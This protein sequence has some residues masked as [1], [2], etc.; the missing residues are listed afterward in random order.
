MKKRIPIL[1]FLILLLICCSSFTTDKLRQGVQEMIFN[2]QSDTN[3]VKFT[4]M[5]LTDA[6]KSQARENIG[7]AALTD[8]SSPYNF[9]GTVAAVSNLP[10]TNNVVNDTYYVTDAKCK[11]TWNGS[12]WYQSSLNEGDYESELAD[13]KSDL[14]EISDVSE[15]IF[16]F[17]NTDTRT[18]GG[19]T[20]EFLDKSTIK[21]NGT[22]TANIFLGINGGLDKEVGYVAPTS[23]TYSGTYS[24]KFFVSG[25]GGLV[26][27]RHNTLNTAQGE[28]IV[29]SGNVRENTVSLDNEYLYFRIHSGNTFT[30]YI[31]NVM[32]VEGS[33]V[34][35][36]RA[37][38]TQY[39]NDKY[40]REQ[41]KNLKDAENIVKLANTPPKKILTW[42]DDDTANI[43]AINSVKE[44]C[45][46]LG[47]RCTLATIT[48]NWTDE[49]LAEL[50]DAQAN[51]YHITT[52]GDSSHTVWRTETKDV[53]DGDLAT[54]ISK[55]QLNG[56]V[57]SNMFVYPGA[58]VDR[59][60]VNVEAIVKKWCECAVKDYVSGGGIYHTGYGQGRY[61]I[62]RRFIDKSAHAEAEYYTNI[63][64]SFSDD[65]CPWYVFGTHSNNST[66]FDSALVTA[67][68]TYAL[69]NGWEIMTLNEAY[70]Y[71]KKYY[72]IQEMYGLN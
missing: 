16:F 29:S 62:N 19:V 45:E 25:T 66:Q 34:G 14:N 11:F 68:L 24:A 4:P 13:V 33:E 51:G 57:D 41:I 7:A 1:L 2:M 5:N 35:G 52:H 53:L 71:R 42:I 15:N 60:D 21:L 49:I 46:S 47:I 31:I 61:L 27:L 36:F 65:D 22:S 10:S 59:T 67:V 70:K 55:L 44:I 17:T 20:V 38:G 64:D 32:L 63:L 6:Q 12:A 56:F 8:V 30:D 50:K 54:S 23:E 48:G 72:D 43:T 28:Q 58:T 18:I 3:S 9:K 37:Y 39:A 40:A 69:E 26:T